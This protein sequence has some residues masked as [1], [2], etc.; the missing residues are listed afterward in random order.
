MRS[1][2][3][4][5]ELLF[6][7]KSEFHLNIFFRTCLPKKEK[8]CFIINAYNISDMVIRKKLL[9]LIKNYD[10]CFKKEKNYDAMNEFFDLTEVNGE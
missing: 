8:Y 7:A 6:T 5:I 9:K 2:I 3:W 10:E 4:A 1:L